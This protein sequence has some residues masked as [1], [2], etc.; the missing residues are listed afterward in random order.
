[1]FSY[2]PYWILFLFI[3]VLTLLDYLKLK[4][5][6]K[7]Y[8]LF[9]VAAVLIFFSGLR[10]SIDNDY[11]NYREI[12]TSLSYTPLH[13][14]INAS[15][16]DTAFNVE[17][18]YRVANKVLSIIF[19]YYQ[20]IFIACA[21]ASVGL[22]VYV[23]SKLSPYPFISVLLYV[24]H[25]YLLRDMMQIRAGVACGLCL[26]SILY[27]KKNRS[28]IFLLLIITAT[29]VHGAAITFLLIYIVYK[30][31]LKK[32][33]LVFLLIISV[34][35]GFIFPF[36]KLLT[37]ILPQSDI[38]YKIQG[39]S[40]GVYSE[41]LGMTNITLLKQVLI[42]SI[43]LYNYSRLEKD[44]KYFKILFV[45]YLIS[46]CWLSIFNDFGIIGGRIG[47]YFSVTEVILI[48]IIIRSY[49]LQ[50]RWLSPVLF[51]V[52]NVY[53]LL[54]FFI[55]IKLKDNFKPYTTFISLI[56]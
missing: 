9:I 18:L 55:N 26:L 51:V 27:L 56:K 39:Y 47:T 17:P 14:V 52:I 30:M 36:G 33:S 15:P 6:E 23:Y 35:I 19:G 12:Y 48:P 44:F 29:M 5:I 41:S 4:V 42:A 11:D 49:I 20:W 28:L 32:R 13:D 10:G 34:I 25:T 2:L 22:N 50:K 46:T 8:V 24:A 16:G 3:S 53:A 1:M 7:N 45:S 37:I 21:C 31:D 40:S 38:F 43:C 54:F